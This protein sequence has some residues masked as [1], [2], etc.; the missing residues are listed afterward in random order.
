MCAAKPE[1]NGEIVGKFVIIDR[2][3]PWAVNSASSAAIMGKF[4]CTLTGRKEASV[5]FH[6]KYFLGKFYSI[7]NFFL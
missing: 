6:E 3:R 4:W 5:Y 1:R 2:L 7:L